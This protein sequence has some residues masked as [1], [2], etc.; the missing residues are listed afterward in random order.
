MSAKK[1][2]YSKEHVKQTRKGV[3]IKNLSS[4]VGK[5]CDAWLEAR[6]MKSSTWKEQLSSK[7]RENN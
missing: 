4:S 1:G 6:G 2:R 7:A 3:S 5:A